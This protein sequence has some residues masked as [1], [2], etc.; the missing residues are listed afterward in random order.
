MGIKVIGKNC[1][2][3]LKRNV[4]GVFAFLFSFTVVITFISITLSRNAAIH[5][6]KSEIA[7]IIADLNEV[8][9][10]IA[11]DKISFNNI[12]IY[13]LIKIE[14]LQIYNLKGSSLWKIKFPEISGRPKLFG[15]GKI[16]LRAGNT[17]EI[18]IDKDTYQISLGSA[19][20]IIELQ[21]NGN[22]KELQTYLKNI[23]IKDFAKIKSLTFISRRLNQAMA[24]RILTPAFES[25]LEVKNFKFNGLIDYPLAAEI[26]R[27]YAKFN[28]MGNIGDGDTF[29]LAA[30]N[31]LKSGGFIE[32]PSVFVNWA[33][34][35][36]VGRGDISFDEKFA[37]K[38]QLQTSS[39]AML[40]L[41][42][43]MQAKSYLDRKGVFVANILLNAKAFKLHNDDKYLTIATPI[44]YRD[45]K[46]AVEN[47]TIKTL[48]PQ[49]GQ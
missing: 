27:I 38:L 23:Q 10:D 40:E 46:L 18:S 35:L 13:P 4:F 42:N 44:T 22:I 48:P 16:N 3:K 24:T 8:D 2:Q 5:S 21:K 14:N 28:L 11:Y 30:E 19:K 7:G 6:L 9:A 39:K 26:Q 49:N 29:L 25:H 47:I 32:I 41:L 1:W 34:L 43:D 33:P 12:F 36:L 37:P 15:F 20:T 45:N 31:W 17:A